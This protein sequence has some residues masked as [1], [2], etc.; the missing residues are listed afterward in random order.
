MWRLA[1]NILPTRVN[2]QKKGITLDLLFPLCHRED[3]SSH[4]LFMKCKLFKLSMFA[5]HIGSHIPLDTDLNDWI[6]KWSTCQD[7]FG[8]QLFCAL[9]W[10]FWAGRNAIVL[11][12]VHLDPTRLAMNVVNFIISLI[13][14]THKEAVQFHCFRV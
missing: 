10:K 1:K 4:H 9:L 7:S 6:L 3:E 11:N 13:K 12:G 14:R 8:V 5:S 2:I